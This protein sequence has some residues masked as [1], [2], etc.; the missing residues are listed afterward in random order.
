MT[1][2]SMGPQQIGGSAVRAAVG[3][4]DAR[5]GH[6][7]AHAGRWDLC[8]LATWSCARRR[9]CPMRFSGVKFSALGREKKNFPVPGLQARSGKICVQSRDG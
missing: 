5:C 7:L 2:R 6:P 8:A 9:M 4:T 1:L 3:R